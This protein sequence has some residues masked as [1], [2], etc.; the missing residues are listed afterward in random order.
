MGS[1]GIACIVLV[2]KS[3]KP[4]EKDTTFQP[5]P[6]APRS[7]LT[8]R[9]GHL[10]WTGG[11]TNPFTGFMLEFYGNESLK[12]RSTI[13]N[14]LLHGISEGWHTNRQLA[15]Q[16]HFRDGVSHGLRIKWHLNGTKLS[17][18]SIVEGQLHG[19]FRRWHENG[20]LAEELE[21][22]QGQAEGISRAFYPSGFLKAKVDLQN[23]K[24]VEQQFW[25]DGEFKEAFA[26]AKQD[27]TNGPVGRPDHRMRSS[28]R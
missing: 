26:A 25:E 13:S 14:G 22:R 19:S 7:E 21:L 15:V 28:P 17:E 3:G 16:E 23:G 2:W 27:I 6:E 12:S 8:L 18:A 24:P 9:E 10:Y 5:L 20:G 11:S 4:Q 1:V